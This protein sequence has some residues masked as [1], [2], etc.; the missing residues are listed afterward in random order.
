MLNI[1]TDASSHDAHLLKA[2]EDKSSPIVYLY[3]GKLLGIC[4]SFLSSTAGFRH[5]FNPATT[6]R[7]PKATASSDPLVSDTAVDRL[8]VPRNL[9]PSFFSRNFPLART[10]CQFQRM[11]PRSCSASNR[12]ATRRILYTLIWK[13]GRQLNSAAISSAVISE[14][15]RAYLLAQSAI[16]SIWIFEK[17]QPKERGAIDRSCERV[18]LGMAESPVSYTRF[19]STHASNVND[20]A[21]KWDIMR[22]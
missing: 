10:V 21:V 16:P 19:N 9:L 4:L 20:A 12:M 13:S 3:I 6:L 11:K 7:M 14:Q 1:L 5:F 8:D 17:A 2:K 18:M 22:S 15:N